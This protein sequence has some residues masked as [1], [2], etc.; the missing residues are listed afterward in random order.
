MANN[1]F[2]KKLEWISYIMAYGTKSYI[3]CHFKFQWVIQ[4]F[5]NYSR[6]LILWRKVLTN[7]CRVCQ[8]F[9]GF[10]YQSNSHVM[11]TTTILWAFKFS[12]NYSYILQPFKLITIISHRPSKTSRITYKNILKPFK[13]QVLVAQLIIVLQN[14]MSLMLLSKSSHLC[15]SPLRW[16]WGT[17]GVWAESPSAGHSSGFLTA[18]GKPH[19]HCPHPRP[20]LLAASPSGGGKKHKTSNYGR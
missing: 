12:N 2:L 16:H 4:I 11:N 17:L 10:K 14:N 9:K 18:L 15:F 13:I 5:Q 7:Y 3:L 20:G 6:Y 1:G 19:L 8:L